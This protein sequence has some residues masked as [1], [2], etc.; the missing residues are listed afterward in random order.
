MIQAWA[1]DAGF[2]LGE[3]N[4]ASIEIRSRDTVSGHTENY[5]IS[6]A[7]LDCIEIEVD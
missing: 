7:G 4:S 6:D 5:T 1:R 2:Q 3:G